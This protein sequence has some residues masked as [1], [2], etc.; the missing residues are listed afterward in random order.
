MPEKRNIKVCGISQAAIEKIDRLAAEKKLSR[1]AYLVWLLESDAALQAF[2]DYEERYRS[3]Q[4][5]TLA[6]LRQNID[7]MQI[8]SEILTGG[9]DENG[10]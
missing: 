6:V 3:L 4:Q 9:S 2:A 7:L 1:N 10:T 5:D 8:I